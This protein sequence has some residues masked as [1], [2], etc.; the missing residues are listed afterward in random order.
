[1]NTED[2]E[3]ETPDIYLA[4]YLK[5]SGCNMI[6]R[7]KQANRIYFV[8]QNPAGSVKEMREAY[9]SGRAKVQAN[10]FAQEIVAMKQL[11]FEF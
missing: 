1:M 2:I 3:F 10:Q 6:R 7:R 5:V 4:A 11:C 9:F 8:F